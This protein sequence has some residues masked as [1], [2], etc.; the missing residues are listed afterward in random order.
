[1]TTS[2]VVI[3]GG[4]RTIQTENVFVNGLALLRHDVLKSEEGKI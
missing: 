1:V 4:E 2:F 3:V